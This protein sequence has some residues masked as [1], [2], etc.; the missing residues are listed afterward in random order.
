MISYGT[1][2]PF[3][4]ISSDITCTLQRSICTWELPSMSLRIRPR[5]SPS[6]PLG[7]RRKR[8]WACSR[9]HIWQFVRHNYVINFMFKENLLTSTPTQTSCKVISCAQRKYSNRWPYLKVGF[10]WVQE[11]EE[12]KKTIR[13]VG[14]F[15]Y[16]SE[17]LTW[18]AHLEHRE[19]SQLCRLHRIPRFWSPRGVWRS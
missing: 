13:W 7:G 5:S 1:G 10:V 2:S 16:I 18:Q 17:K 12:H 11:M 6:Y 19:S 15:L 9:A 8:D 3:S 14:I 4:C